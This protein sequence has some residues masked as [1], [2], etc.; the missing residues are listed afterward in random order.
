MFLADRCT[1]SPAVF[2]RG[3]HCDIQK[4]TGS[5]P[6][7]VYF[8]HNSDHQITSVSIH[9]LNHEN[10]K[11]FQMQFANI[12]IFIIS[13]FAKILKSTRKFVYK[14]LSYGDANLFS[15]FHENV[16]AKTSLINRKC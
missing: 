12:C 3:D 10:G 14:I 7:E 1:S 11:T 13:F 8:V 9:D 15:C 16:D 4:V 2:S 6:S 5:L